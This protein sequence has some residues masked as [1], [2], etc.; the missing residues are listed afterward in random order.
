MRSQYLL[1]NAEY[2]VLDS[3]RVDNRVPINNIHGLVWGQYV[4][5]LGSGGL[6]INYITLTYGCSIEDYIMAVYCPAAAPSADQRRRG[7]QDY[8]F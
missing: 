2:S 4:A 8:G 6:R 3:Y 5:I 1:G 7:L